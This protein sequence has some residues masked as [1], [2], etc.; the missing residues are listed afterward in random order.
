MGYPGPLAVWPDEVPDAAIFTRFR[1]PEAFSD[2]ECAEDRC[3][4][5]DV[6]RRRPRPVAPMGASRARHV[7]G[8][9]CGAGSAWFRSNDPSCSVRAMSGLPPRSDRG[10]PRADAVV[11]PTTLCSRQDLTVIA[12]LG[13][14]VHRQMRRQGGRGRPDGLAGSRTER[15][16]TMRRG[17]EPH[18]G[19]VLPVLRHDGRSARQHLPCRLLKHLRPVGTRASGTNPAQ[20]VSHRGAK[21][22]RRTQP[23]QRSQAR[24]C[25]GRD[26]GRRESC[27][28]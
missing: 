23:P 19:G 10:S 12:S 2:G 6:P 1:R 25:A 14:K 5:A 4:P 16:E 11:I 15:G 24:S 22:A 3:R 18:R 8:S 27:G 20:L 13:F 21:P 9:R 28:D 26:A 7:N 17:L